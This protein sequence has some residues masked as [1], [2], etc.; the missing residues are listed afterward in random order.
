MLSVLTQL[1]PEPILA[2]FKASGLT[3]DEVVDREDFILLLNC[4][5]F[6]SKKHVDKRPLAILQGKIFSTMKFA[7]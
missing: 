7:E 6:G 4:L 1:L 2:D 5:F 3:L